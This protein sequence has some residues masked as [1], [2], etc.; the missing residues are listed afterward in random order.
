MTTYQPES[1]ETIHQLNSIALE[2]RKLRKETLATFGV[3]VAVDTSTGLPSAHY[4]PMYQAGQITAYKKRTLPKV[5]TAVG[6]ARKCELFG[7]NLNPNGGKLLIITEGELDAMAVHQ[8]TKDRNGGQNAYKVASLTTGGN[9]NSIKLNLEWIEQFEK[10][11]L[12]FDNDKV[13]QE[14]QEAAAELLSPGKAALLSF[15]EGIKD[16]CDVLI[17]SPNAAKV[18]MDLLYSARTFQPSGIVSGADTW[19]ALQN[20]ERVESLPYPDGW[21]LNQKTYGIRLGEL[22]TWTSGSGSGKTA[23]IRELQFHI[24]Q[25]TESN[26]GIIALEEPLTDSVEALMALYLNKRIQLPDVEYTSDEYKQAWD[27]CAGTN[28]IHLYDHFGSTDSD[29]LV[30]KIKYMAKG[31]DCKYIFLDHLSIVVS[32]FAADGD[33]RKQIDKIMTTLKRLTQELGIWIGLVVHLRKTSSG[34]SFEEGAVPSTD[35]LRGSGSIKQLSNGV[36]AIARN[37]QHADETVRNTSSV[38]SLKCR[39]TGRTGAAGFLYFDGHT[40]RMFPVDD[41]EAAQLA[42]AEAALSDAPINSFGERDSVG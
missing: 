37:Q 36:F 38:H 3:K 15:P 32:E 19:E 33:E 12:A 30:S 26:I 21:D 9:I 13:G 23:V 31:L 11:V 2:D 7:Q 22:D 16:A 20:R 1:I 41:P 10:V 27:Y 8:M 4:Y 42:E 6:D 39:F 34:T 24:M 25:K 18:F 29:T 40:G 28:R 14:T 17:H 5:F 35:D